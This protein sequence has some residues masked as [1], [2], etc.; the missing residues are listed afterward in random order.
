VKLGVC[1]VFY[2]NV[3]LGYTI[4]GVEVTVK[5]DTHKTNVDQFGK[6]TINEFI[7]SRD[8]NVKVPLAET[9]LDN[10]MA[11]MPGSTLVTD[12]VA[13]SGTITIA[14]Q[15]TNAQTITVAGKTLTFKTVPVAELDVRIGATTAATA[16]NLAYAIDSSIDGVV[17]T[18]YA[19]ASNN[20]VTVKA[21]IR[22]TAG[23]S[24][25]LVTGTAGASVT[26]SAATLTG[27]V[28]VTKARVD[29]NTGIG[30]D[31][32]SISK[33]LRLHPVGKASYDR[34]DDFIIQKAATPG[35]L[36]FAY[37]I[38]SERVYNVEFGGFPDPVTGRLFSV[39]DP[40][41]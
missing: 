18:L 15:P 22:G 1:Q 5:T 8:V 10:L 23:N 38:D 25:A 3:D 40:L 31:L 17:N 21:D 32:L 24:I 2:D 27:G 6:T 20:V 36:T 26:M 35:A 13:A 11:I 28:D 30:V 29:V 16:Q 34:S 37:K 9:T 39:G 41:A 33:E 19:T 14:T 7:M 4:G 12:G